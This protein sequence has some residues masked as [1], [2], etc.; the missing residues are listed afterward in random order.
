MD[1]ENVHN[2]YEQLVFDEIQ[3]HLQSRGLQCDYETLEDVACIAL[4]R[5]PPRYVSNSVDMAFFLTS[6]DRL[7]MD[8]AVEKAVKEGFEIVTTNPRNR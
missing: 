7:K 2:Y 6:E 3:T 1:L 5:L 4:N 8:Q